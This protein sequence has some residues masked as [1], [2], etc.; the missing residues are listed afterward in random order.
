ML[1][2]SI[3]TGIVSLTVLGV[4]R[5]FAPG[6][7]WIWMKS[8]AIAYAIVIPLIL[9]VSPKVQRIV[10]QVFQERKYASHDE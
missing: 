3:T 10:N 6:L 8:W 9:I 1:M 5:G 2:G 7:A 4:N